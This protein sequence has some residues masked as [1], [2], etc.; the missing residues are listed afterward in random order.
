MIFITIS[1]NL[2]DLFI[3]YLV[4]VLCFVL[5][6]PGQAGDDSHIIAGDD[7]HIVAGDD[8]H[9]AAGDDYHIVAEDDSHI[10]AG[11]DCHVIAGL[12]GNLS[13]KDKR[14]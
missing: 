3:V 14:F 4:Y 5:Q 9:T 7:S 10:V 1:L 2:I 8:G 6:I 11:D 13:S 12:T